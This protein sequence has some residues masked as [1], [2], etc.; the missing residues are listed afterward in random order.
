[1]TLKELIDDIHSLNR[2]LEEYE[3]KYGIAS[4]D[5]YKLYQQGTLDEGDFEEIQEF[6]EWA[7]VYQVKVKQEQKNEE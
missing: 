1:M 4:E 2:E 3:R 7:G 6:C 5:F